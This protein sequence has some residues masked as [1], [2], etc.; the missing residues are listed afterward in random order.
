MHGAGLYA[1][2]AAATLYTPPDHSSTSSLIC[3]L[4]ARKFVTTASPHL[5]VRRFTYVPVP[6]FLHPLSTLF[7]GRTGEDLFLAD[8]NQS[9]D[10]SLFGLSPHLFSAPSP[11]FAFPLHFPPPPSPLL[12]IPSSLPLSIPLPFPSPFPLPLSSS[13]SSPPS[14]SSR[15]LFL[16]LSPRFLPHCHPPSPTPGLPTRAPSA[17]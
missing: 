17:H 10:P 8:G 13:P 9:F 5:G 12:P 14:L 16:P 6:D 7:V 1:R 15:P 4:K 3:G 2:Y 11:S